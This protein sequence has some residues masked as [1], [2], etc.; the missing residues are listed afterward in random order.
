MKLME[1][2]LLN[3]NTVR[4][5]LR[6]DVVKNIFYITHH[7]TLLNRSL[8]I[9]SLCQKL[10]PKCKISAWIHLHYLI[11][12]SYDILASSFWICQEVNDSSLYP[13]SKLLERDGFFSFCIHRDLK[14]FTA[15][16]S[17]GQ[18]NAYFSSRI[19]KMSMKLTCK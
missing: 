4:S 18:I 2:N 17:R 3:K 8:L 19:D 5:K 14:Q 10:S 16:L 6:I 9:L 13:Q 1:T 11:W 15:I 12:R 7:D